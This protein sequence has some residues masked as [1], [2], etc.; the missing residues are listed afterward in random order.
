ML[1]TVEGVLTE[2]HIFFLMDIDSP[3]SLKCM[4]IYIVSCY[5]N[6]LDMEGKLGL[7]KSAIVSTIV[8]SGQ[9][10]AWARMER[11]E[12]PATQLSTHLNKEIKA[13]VRLIVCLIYLLCHPIS[14]TI[15]CYNSISLYLSTMEFKR[16]YQSRR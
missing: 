10:G 9:D 13:L 15:L 16:H 7:E 14:L 2:I 4:F 1:I 12:F 3:I 11:G 5:G 8:K 6:V